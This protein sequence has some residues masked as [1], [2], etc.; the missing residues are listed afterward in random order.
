MGRSSAGSSA[1]LRVLAH[2]LAAWVS[3]G[4]I[5]LAVWVC[6]RTTLSAP[7]LFDDF[8]AISG[9]PTLRHLTAIGEVLSPPNDGSGVTGRPI[10]NLSLA[11]NFA[12]GGLE[13]RGYHFTNALL[14][15][16]A[17]L[18]LFGL[19]RRTLRLRT[20]RDRFGAMADPLALAIAMLW[21]LHPLQT[22][23][24]TCV[25][26][27]TEVLV[28]LWYLLT[29]YCFARGLEEGAAALWHPLA[30]GSCLL[31]MASKEVMV[32]A[33][34]LALL[35]DRTFAAGTFREAIR[36]RWRTYLGLAA[37]WLLLG[38]LV[39]RGGGSRGAAAGFGLGISWWSY[40]LKQCDAIVLY[41]RLVF[42]PHP[43]VLDYGTKVVTRPADIWPQAVL[44]VGLVSAALISLR[45]RPS[46]GFAGMWFFAIL[47]PSSSVVPLVTQTVAEHRMYLPLAAVLALVVVA[48]FAYGGPR[49]LLVS[50]GVV[51][52]LGWS[53]IRRNG[54]YATAVGIW[55]DSLAKVGDNNRAR[56][57]LAGAL[58]DA[59][60]LPE[61]LELYRK[62]VEA[63]PNNAEIYGNISG[64]FII[65]GRYQE[66]IAPA[67]KAVKLKPSLVEAHVNLGSALGSLGRHREAITHLRAALALDP[68]LD[69]VRGNIAHALIQLGE[70][71]EAIV[72][73]RLAVR[74]NPDSVAGHA[75]WGEALL[76]LK[77]P[78]EAIVHCQT[79]VRLQPENIDAHVNLAT[80]YFDA[81]RPTEAIEQYRTA[82]R[83]APN[84]AGIR[85]NFALALSNVGR[86]VEAIAEYE[87]L[88][89]RA[90]GFFV[91]HLNLA[92][93]LSHLGRN[94]DALAHAEAALRLQPDSPDAR[95]AI[96]AFRNPPKGR[97]DAP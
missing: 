45:R 56:V 81:G 70:F 83:L 86:M 47:A 39:M 72:H 18:A 66:A 1:S 49:T 44:L 80:A 20:M 58:R 97:A 48:G 74:E 5:V 17:G 38:F 88:L 13:P 28:G 73:C 71:E 9:N 53:T 95:R 34:L 7:F 26:Q 29:L 67:E 96:D 61:A 12:L 6:Y 75:G 64:L 85:S 93:V 16:A 32:S 14:H 31:G 4:V 43:L 65:A 87:E 90:P 92:Y 40:A 2:P 77:R 30:C 24:V 23:S 35:Y 54:D 8:A 51:P 60:R 57:N 68:R 89:R 69:Y 15:A 50:L 11:V 59:G 25:I 82:I 91:A 36:L 84:N 55:A 22:E 33:P 79:A 41:L 76:G 19:A 46:V 3:A 62:A 94:T 63:E 52:L 21:T 27:R 10:V 37:T 42:W 78:A